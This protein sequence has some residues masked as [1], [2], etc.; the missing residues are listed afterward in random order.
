MKVEEKDE[1]G[2]EKHN[3]IQ[4]NTINQ[5]QHQARNG[6]LKPLSPLLLKAWQHNLTSAGLEEAMT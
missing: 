4:Y 5:S 2:G 1:E 3:T 6:E